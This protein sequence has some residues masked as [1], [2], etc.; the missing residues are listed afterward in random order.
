MAEGLAEL[1]HMFLCGLRERSQYAVAL[2]EV[3]KQGQ[4]TGEAPEGETLLGIS[5]VFIPGG[6]YTLI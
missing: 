2:K 6:H 1:V 3:S 5:N 4:T